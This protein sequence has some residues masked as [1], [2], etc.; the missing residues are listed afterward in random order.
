MLRKH[1]QFLKSLFFILDLLILFLAWIFSYVL[2]FYTPL[3]RPPI[4]GTPDFWI[5]LQFSPLLLILWSLFAK[6]SNLYRPRRVEFFSRELLEVAKCLTFA[7]IILIAIIY[8][9]R[10]FEFSR[11]GFF[12]FWGLG[13]LG[14]LSVRFF[15]R[16]LLKSLRKRGYNLRF[17][18]IAGTGPL[19]QKLL[20]KIELHQQLG[21]KV[22]GFLTR[23]REEVGK[24]INGVPVLGHYD[25]LTTILGER[26]VDIFFIA[27]S[28]NE[29]SLFEKMVQKVLGTLPEIKVVP[30]SYEFLGLRGGL[31]ELDGLPMV[32]L[33]GSPLF[34]WDRVFKRLFDLILGSLIL[35]IVSPLMVIIGLLIKSTSKGPVLYRQER[36]GMDGNTF[37]MLKFRTMRVD[38]E[39]ETGPA[40]AKV[41]DPRRT[42]IGALLRKTSLDELPQLLNVLKGEMSL[43]GPRPER[44][45][46]VEQF[47][48][49]IP[50]YMLRHKIK[51]GMTGWAQV[52][53]WRGDTSIEKRIEHDLYYIQNW[54]IGL[55]LRIL[56]MTLWKGFFSK[57]AY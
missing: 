24:T 29:Y 39:K 37:Q 52:N 20:E 44:A 35:G 21:I 6:K 34:G 26:V 31:D 17:A 36:I 3:I 19:G 54:S 56:W 9:F 48:S 14:L 8:L 7:L 53:G 13:M 46:F 50:S 32:S 12:Y 23:E 11:L 30:A 22:F 1:A 16:N 45:Y 49:N 4:L 25:D 41:N 33:Q 55:D 18:L 5:Y 38:A 40:W 15:T 28:V 2:R 42:S 51:T 47:R 10:R 43:V 27:L 57:S